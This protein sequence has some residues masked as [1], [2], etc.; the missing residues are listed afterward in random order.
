MPPLATLFDF[1]LLDAATFAGTAAVAG[2]ATWLTLGEWRRT[3]GQHWTERARALY[4]ARVACA[5]NGIL[6]LLGA[7]LVA[8]RVS[9]SFADSFPWS[10]LLAAVLGSFAG[11]YPLQRAVF[12]DQTL[13][14][15]IAA[16][17]MQLSLQTVVVGIFFACVL[18]MPRNFGLET[19]L[20]AAGW[21]AMQAVLT[22]GLWLRF[23]R[24]LRLL[25]PPSAR[26]ARIVAETSE[27]TGIPVRAVWESTSAAS[28]AAAAITSRTLI[29]TRP[30]VERLSDAEIESICLHELAHL[31]EPKSIVRLRVLAQ[32]SRTP[33]LFTVPVA[34]QFGPGVAY[35]LLAVS[36]G[37]PFALIRARR[38]MEQRAD[39]LAAQTTADPAIYARALEKIYEANQMPAVVSGLTQGVHPNLY[40]RMVAAGVTPDYARPA[41]PRRFHWTSGVLLIVVATAFVL[42]VVFDY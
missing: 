5:L 22:S 4:R 10:A 7:V 2:A 24:L 23:L 11:T 31:T 3:A 25:L 18:F 36:V 29:F 26:L 38:R 35:V 19:W 34:A 8:C 40:D 15:W 28:Q 37:L 30:L 6:V 16:R 20:L 41:K 21:L 1:V 14:A 12:P 33:L 39:R 42:L 32:F 17:A 9:D 13:K 27:R